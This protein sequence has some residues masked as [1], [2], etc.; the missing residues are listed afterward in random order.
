MVN[1]AVR[2]AASYS[3]LTLLVAPVVTF[4][5]ARSAPVNDAGLISSAN[6]T[7]TRC[8]AGLN[9]QPAGAGAVVSTVTLNVLRA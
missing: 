2:V 3:A 7:C 8:V 1:D 4:S 5:S 9:A 6:C